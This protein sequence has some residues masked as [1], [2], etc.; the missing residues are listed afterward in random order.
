MRYT[1]DDRLFE[2]LLGLSDRSALI[3][4]I[5]FAIFFPFILFID[6]NKLSLE[7]I[8]IITAFEMFFVG[9]I[10]YLADKVIK[11]ARK[12]RERCEREKYFFD[13]DRTLKRRR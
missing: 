4:C 11:E 13:L 8:L 7:F 5:I 10:I 1:D 6:I 12:E 2:S 3:L 9:S